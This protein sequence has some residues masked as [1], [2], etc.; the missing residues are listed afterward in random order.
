MIRHWNAL[1][2][3]IEKNQKE[4]QKHIDKLESEINGNGNE[5]DNE[6]QN[7]NSTSSNKF[8]RKRFLPRFLNANK[9]FKKSN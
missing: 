6:N 4:M 2:R 5:N 1:K 7:Q 3:A 9:G 8:H